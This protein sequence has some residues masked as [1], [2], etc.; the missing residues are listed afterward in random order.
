MIDRRQLLRGGVGA[1]LGRALIGGGLA[2]ALSGCGA[3]PTPEALTGGRG[4]RWR[5]RGPARSTVVLA[6]GLGLSPAM[7]DLP[8]YGGLAPALAWRGH[9][10][11]SPAL[12][13]EGTLDDW[14]AALEASA[15]AHHG[16]TPVIG[17][18]LDLGGTALY[19]A[20]SFAAVATIGAPIARGGFSV[21]MK[22][23]LGA[24]G[25]TTWAALGSMKIGRWPLSRLI[26]THG[27]PATVWRPLL[28]QALRPIGDPLRR[29]WSGSAIGEPVPILAEE[30]APPV[31]ARTRP[32]LVMSAP[33]D[34]LAPPWQCDPAAF[35]IRWDG[36]ERRRF[37]RATGAQRE[38][39]HLDLVIHPTARLDVWP[40]LLDWIE[41]RL[42]GLG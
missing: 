5:P 33:T 17:V 13:A 39:N 23:V 28:A 19:R 4:Q 9:R 32:T 6:H 37:S 8:G 30:L 16:G 41:S 27:L 35:G 20:S 12:P 14:T 18:G 31:T 38:F 42:D 1:L 24:P 11:I 22:R 21:A 3:T 15:A 7:W 26:L 10:V 2:S 34:G 36:L 29:L 25:R 40:G